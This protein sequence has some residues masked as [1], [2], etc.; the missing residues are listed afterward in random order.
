MIYGCILFLVIILEISVCKPE[1][2]SRKETSVSQLFLCFYPLYSCWHIFFLYAVINSTRPFYYCC[3]DQ[4]IFVYIYQP[5]YLFWYSSLPPA[6]TGHCFPSAW[7]ISYN[8]FWNVYLLTVNSHILKS[9]FLIH[10][11]VFLRGIEIQIGTF[12]PSHHFNYVISLFLAPIFFFFKVIYHFFF[13]SKMSFF[14][15]FLFYFF[16]FW[17]F[18]SLS[19][20]CLCTVF[21]NL[22]KFIELLESVGYCGLIV[23]INFGSYWPL[24]I[25]IFAFSS[26][27]S[28]FWNSH[29]YFIFWLFPYGFCSSFSFFPLCFNFK[30]VH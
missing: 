25:Q 21:L 19:K 1:F 16:V 14:S 5:I 4:L 8:T 15:C 17:F 27:F 28:I 11:W 29:I 3:L 24:S 22:I 7:R 20:M 12:F 6:F 2:N 9:F 13:D 18:N 30:I 26:L 10:Y 23:F